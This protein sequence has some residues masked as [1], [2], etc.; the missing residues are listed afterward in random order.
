[1]FNTGDLLLRLR[2]II[3]FKNNE[4]FQEVAH[5]IQ[6]ML[7]L[8]DWFIKF[9]LV[10]APIDTSKELGIDTEAMGLC[11]YDYG[12]H[13]AVIKVQNCANAED[14][15][16]VSSNIALLDLIHEELHLKEEYISLSDCYKDIDD[17]DTDIDK[18]HKHM[19]LEKMAKSIFMAL[20]GVT[21]DFFMK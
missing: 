4:E 17:K 11:T 19:Y 12:N 8:D 7:F 16:L 14:D 6:H 1:M 13:E 15:I 3:K 21:K 10:D 9:E 20:T 2:P 18:V 5:Y